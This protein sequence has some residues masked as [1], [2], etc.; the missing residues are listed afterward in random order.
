MSLINQMLQDL[1]ARRAAESMGSGLPNEVRPLPVARQTRWPLIAGAGILLAAV[2]GGAA[3]YLLNLRPVQV[4]LP[5]MPLTSLPVP[6]PVAASALSSSLPSSM[7]ASTPAPAAVSAV[8][9]APVAALPEPAI[10]AEREPDLRLTTSLLLPDNWPSA[11]VKPAAKAAT[12]TVIASNST[13]AAPAPRQETAPLTPRSTGA[14]SVA[15]SVAA[16]PPV[17]AASAVAIEK[18]TPSGSVSDRAEVEYRRAQSVL[19]QGRAAET[20]DILRQALRFNA[21][22]LASRQLL[23]KL[24]IENKQMDDASAVLREGLALHPAQIAW[25]MS[26]ARMQLDRGD[27]AGSWKI[28]ENSLPS[29]SGSSDYQGFAA[30]VLQ[31]LGR[32]REAIEYYQ[33]A[34]R[35]AP[36]EGRWWLG[37]G[38]ALESDGRATDARDALLRA[39][40]SGTLSPELIALVD[41]KLR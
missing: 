10:P 41:Q 40:A 15:G 32:T 19:N 26:L 31:R 20:L 25:A 1:D 34:T 17:H 35:L 12:A 27:L 22:H 14:G 33:A 7:P 9:S 30:H 4:T 23:L 29:A 24:L 16:N 6:V 5:T 2:A 37:L 36:A 13:P 39:R 38:I 11:P 28:L 8:V 21:A 18:S 3:W